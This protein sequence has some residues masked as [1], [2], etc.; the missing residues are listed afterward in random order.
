VRAFISKH[1][2]PLAI[3]GALAL[4]ASA[5]FLTAAAVGG[6]SA[7]TPQKTVTISIPTGTGP[8]GPAGPEGPAGPPG[9]PGP[10]GPAGSIDC[11]AGSTF[12]KLVIIVQGQGPTAIY[13][14]IVD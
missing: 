6:S 10:A 8:T 7:L 13:S 14:C 11:P 9:E 12:G 1:T 5:G 2:V 4:A 3:G